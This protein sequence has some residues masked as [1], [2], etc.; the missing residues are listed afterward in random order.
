MC[1]SV[2]PGV[3]PIDPQ[4]PP[5]VRST[6]QRQHPRP[7]AAVG[8]RMSPMHQRTNAPG[9]PDEASARDRP[10]GPTDGWPAPQLGRAPHSA[11]LKLPPK[12][13][14]CGAS[15]HGSERVAL[16]H[17]GSAARHPSK[18]PFE[19]RSH[20]E[21]H[22]RPGSGQC[23]VSLSLLLD[24]TRMLAPGCAWGSEWAAAW[25]PGCMARCILRPDEARRTVA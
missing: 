6:A 11:N 20:K 9:P 5:P 7:T 23:S 13:Q 1:G 12:T 24:A 8:S 14:R 16:G 22:N 4:G 18:G 25:A 2:G 15:A 3:G 21:Q 19:P 10:P 17:H